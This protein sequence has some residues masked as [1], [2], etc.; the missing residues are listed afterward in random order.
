[1]VAA[2]TDDNA[3]LDTAEANVDVLQSLLTSL[4][5]AY[6]SRMGLQHKTCFCGCSPLWIQNSFVT[7]S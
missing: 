4:M 7:R 3:S 2:N 1:M 6:R 5:T